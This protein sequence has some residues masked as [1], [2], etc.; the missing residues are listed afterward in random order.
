MSSRLKVVSLLLT[1]LLGVSMPTLAIATS[2]DAAVPC[3]NDCREN[4]YPAHRTPHKLSDGVVEAMN[5]YPAAH[6]TSYI[7][8]D[9]DDDEPDYAGSLV[10]RYNHMKDVDEMD[11]DT[12]NLVQQSAAPVMDQNAT[13]TRESIMSGFVRGAF[14]SLRAMVASATPHNSSSHPG[15]ILDTL[16]PRRSSTMLSNHHPNCS[17]E[18]QKCGVNTT[19]E[20]VH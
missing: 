15:F 8:V 17:S 20:G 14:D 3:T 5:T 11:E 4:M 7:P 16:F 9:L 1:S 2:E 18:S 19:H 6:N 12:D 13:G 10:F